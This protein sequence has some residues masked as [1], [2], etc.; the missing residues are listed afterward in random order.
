MELRARRTFHGWRRLQRLLPQGLIQ[1]SDQTGMKFRFFSFTPARVP[2]I[3]LAI[4]V[5]IAAASLALVSCKNK[6]STHASSKSG[7]WSA[8]SQ[9]VGLVASDSSSSEGR[10]ILRA[11]LRDKAALVAFCPDDI[12]RCAHRDAAF[13]PAGFVSTGAEGI[14]FASLAALDLRLTKHVTVFV[15]MAGGGLV[16]AEFQTTDSAAGPVL[17]ASGGGPAL[18]N[19]ADPAALGNGQLREFLVGPGMDKGAPVPEIVSPDRWVPNPEQLNL[20]EGERDMVRR[21]N[22]LRA[23]AG[24]P[25]LIV[26]SQLMVLA[27]SWSQSVASRMI[28][29][30]H[31]PYGVPENAC[32]SPPG[33]FSAAEA[34]GIWKYHVE[35][36]QRM[37][38]RDFRFIGVG[39]AMDA[40]GNYHW[41][42]QFL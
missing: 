38:S 36:S 20:T 11:A 25:P 18:C 32:C 23:T 37:N 2:A 14:V 3:G 22:E 35:A 40:Y 7:T 5:A 17:I 27:R 10:S 28:A 24:L 8:N 26:S 41:Y 31:S 4:A 9:G 33:P 12:E 15:R 21:T 19:G 16:C 39:G 1:F 34:L 30:D 13:V 6:T 42:Q 29:N